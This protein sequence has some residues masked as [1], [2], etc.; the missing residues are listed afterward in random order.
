MTSG[1][2][3]RNHMS[4][5]LIYFIVVL[6][7][8]SFFDVISIAGYDDLEKVFQED[9]EPLSAKVPNENHG[10]R[11]DAPTW[12]SL[13]GSLPNV[14]DYFGIDFGDVNNDGK[15]D[16]IVASGD[17]TYEGIRCFVG[18]GNGGWDNQSLGL[19]LV[20]SYTDL[21]VADLNNDGKLDIACSQLYG[22]LGIWTGNGGEGGYMIWTSQNSPGYWN[23]VALGD[24]NNDGIIDIAAGRDSG[25]KVWTSNGGDG[26]FV[27]TDSSGGL[28]AS[29]QFFGVFL[30]DVNNDGKLDIVVGCNQNQGVRVWTGNGESGSSA[31]WSDA[32]TGS[33]LPL[34][35]DYRQVCL[36]DANN[37]G[38]LDIAA[39]TRSQGVRFWKGNG[40]E[41]SFQWKE[42]S[43][44]LATTADYYGVAFGDVNNDG[45]L[46]IVAG[47][48]SN[49]GIEVWLGDGGSGGSVDWT[50]GKEG[51]PS[52]TSIIDVC[53][54]DVN[55]DGRL[56]IGASTFSSGVQIWAGNLPDLAITGWTSASTG[57]PSSSNWYDVTFG[58]VNHDGKLD[59]AVASNSNLGVR[60]YL[61]DGT[62]MWAE[63]LGT[64]LPSSGN[65]NGV[66]LKDVN[67]DGNLDVIASSN[68]LLGVR[69]WLGDGAGGFGPASGPS[70]PVSPPEMGGVEVADIN[71]DG[72]IDLASCRYNPNGGD[73]DDKVYIWLGDG[74]GGWGPDIGPVEDLGYDD[75]ALGDV[76][77]D[78]ALDLLATG[79]MDGYRFWL[80]DET[81]NMILQPQNGLPTTS[82]GLGAFFGDVDHDGHLDIAIGSWAPGASGIRVFTSN[83]GING[84]VW[85]TEESNGLPTAGEHAGMELGDI[86][87]DG[88]LD[89]LTSTCYGEVNGIRLFYG[90]GGEGGTINWADGLLPNLPTTG[91]YWGVAL[92]DVNNDGVLDLAVS[93]TGSGVVVYIAQHRPSFNIDL[94]EGWNL[95]SLPLIQSDTNVASVL[96][97]INGEYKAVQWYDPTDTGDPWKHYEP[98]KPMELNDLRDLDHTQGIWIYITEP[99]GTTLAVFGDELTIGESITIHPG[100]NLVGYPSQSD[101]QVSVALNNLNWVTDIDYVGYFDATTDKFVNLT[102]SDLME[103]GRGYYMHSVSVSELTWNVP[104]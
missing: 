98:Q 71:N 86:N 39:A 68:D 12:S 101:K 47:N 32:F 63:I 67:H 97:S 58:D 9:N 60:V 27:W 96:F 76:N 7:I 21:E 65:Y 74:I 2:G 77:H 89:M 72:N 91:E 24:V 69:V 85:W 56:D 34:T 54:G 83:G 8:L 35:G 55:N 22:S 28:P 23:G 11:S 6:M 52:S 26:G 1:V 75:V 90:D 61:G 18:D 78:G 87:N 93:S 41:G 3:I 19:P 15:L 99:G 10:V 84:S 66:R 46:D 53:V 17:W 81:G 14:S 16:V 62:G 70:D 73:V 92:G 80:G 51:L 48:Y 29:G 20:G 33:G 4:W 79:H 82:S 30:G 59:L 64:N 37:D 40:G 36:G 50:L 42:E 5:Y 25:L 44:G 94:L 13:S 57:L 100:W 104:L 45:K 31:L 88:D 103:V 95:I 102:G 49:G 38:K 43:D